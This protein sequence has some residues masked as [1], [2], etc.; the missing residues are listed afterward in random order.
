MPTVRRTTQDYLDIMAH[1]LGK[2]P[3]S[4]HKLIHD[5]NDAGRALVLAHEWAWRT[6]AG[7]TLDIVAGQ[8]YV[9]LPDDFGS[10]VDVSVLNS[11]VYTI[12]LT[13]VEDINNKRAW[14]Q[15]DA[16]N[17]FMAFDVGADG[18]TD[19]DGVEENRALIWP[20]PQT[21][22]SDIKLTYRK[23]WSDLE[24]E[25]PDRVPSI[26]RDFERSLVLFARSFAVDIENQVDPYENQALF[27]ATGEIQRLIL[28]DAGRQTNMGP[29][30][31]NVIT[32]SYGRPSRPFNRISPPS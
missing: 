5:L 4:R 6:R 25:D 1:A 17:L 12:H 31:H 7:V 24:A 10:V 32:R 9:E 8:D 23:K 21:A 16:I 27:G 3:D 28:N 18:E 29:P 14:E 2:T 15:F 22:R 13:T 11:T 20:T 26:P 19:Q 30:K